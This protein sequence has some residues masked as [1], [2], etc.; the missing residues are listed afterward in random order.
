MASLDSDTENWSVNGVHFK[1][2]ANLAHLENCEVRPAWVHVNEEL[3][4]K[5]P[6]L[7]RNEA[8]GLGA[9]RGESLILAL[10][11]SLIRTGRYIYNIRASKH[12]KDSFTKISVGN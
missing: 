4:G 9:R 11:T 2:Q 6:R 5:T 10:H 8:G 1:I 3:T 7:G 12:L